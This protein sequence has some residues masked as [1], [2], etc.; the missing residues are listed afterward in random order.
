[1]D[2]RTGVEKQDRND[3]KRLVCGQNGAKLGTDTTTEMKGSEM[4]K[5]SDDKRTAVETPVGTR[6]L[7]EDQPWWK[8]EGRG[9]TREFVLDERKQRCDTCVDRLP[10]SAFPTLT[11]PRKDGRYRGTTCRSCVRDRRAEKAERE[12]R[13]EAARKAAATRA[14]RKAR[15]ATK[16]TVTATAA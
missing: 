16:T 1:M 7:R 9:Y 10:E 5:T 4:G 12:R 2:N 11:V 6:L 14:S 15:T 8:G 3:R 13:S